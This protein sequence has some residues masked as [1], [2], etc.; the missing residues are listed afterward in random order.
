MARAS[1]LLK[2]LPGTGGTIY[3]HVFKFNTT[4]NHHLSIVNDILE[5]LEVGGE[6]KIPPT[7]IWKRENI[8]LPM[9][10]RMMDFGPVTN[11]TVKKLRLSEN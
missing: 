2:V 8:I 9:S 5:D 3:I 4:H 6:I 7:N 11:R 1:R 10:T